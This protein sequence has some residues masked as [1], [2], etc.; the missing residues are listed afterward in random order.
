MGW[1]EAR[2]GNEEMETERLIIRRF[3]A[4]DWMDMHEYLSNEAVVK[5]EP[6]EV[7]REAQSKR[8]AANRARSR[9]F[10][11]VCLKATGKVIGNLYLHPEEYNTFEMGYVM[12]QD[13]QGKGYATE[14]ATRLFAFVFTV[15]RGH[16]IIARCN[17]ENIASWRV[18]EKLHMRR[19]GHHKKD[20][21]FRLGEDSLP[22]WQDTYQYAILRKEW[23]AGEG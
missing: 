4:S 3:K 6:Y 11:A 23:E 7:F 14:A 18:M 9:E 10:W 22:L 12:H 21:Y 20:V 17:P 8:E 15:L 2:T 16:R 5:Y 1:L 13:Y 19:E